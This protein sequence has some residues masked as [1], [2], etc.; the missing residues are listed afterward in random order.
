MRRVGRTPTATA[1]S[2]KSSTARK[3]PLRFEIKVNSGNAVRK[4]VALVLMDELRKRGIAAQ[5]AASS[6]GRSF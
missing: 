3:T 5:R 4:S 1:F 2:T 6:T